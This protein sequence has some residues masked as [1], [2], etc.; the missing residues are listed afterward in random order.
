VLPLLRTRYTARNLLRHVKVVEILSQ[1]HTATKSRCVHNK[2]GYTWI[3]GEDDEDQD[4]DV[5]PRFSQL[6]D[7][8]PFLEGCR[9]GGLRS[10][11]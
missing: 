9:D 1:F 6:A 10:F 4:E 7:L 11:T 5:H 2:T 8:I 3:D